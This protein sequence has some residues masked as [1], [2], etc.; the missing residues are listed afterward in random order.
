[1]RAHCRTTVVA[2]IALVLGLAHAGARHEREHERLESELTRAIDRLID[3]HFVVRDV[4]SVRVENL[5]FSENGARVQPTLDRNGHQKTTTHH[6]GEVYFRP[7]PLW[8]HIYP[9]SGDVET[10]TEAPGK[11]V[12]VA[13]ALRDLEELKEIGEYDL[14]NKI[15][16]LL[17]ETYQAIFE[18]DSLICIAMVDLHVELLQEVSDDMRGWGHLEFSLMSPVFGT[19]MT[20]RQRGNLTLEFVR[21][22]FREEFARQF[23][24]TPRWL[25]KQPPDMD[26]PR[27]VHPCQA[28]D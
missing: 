17:D 8:D 22:R 11:H 15:F 3:R 2:V 12:T 23:H 20:A 5:R 7:V 26:P 6:K 27:K 25:L 4:H 21:Y 24:D 18:S 1:M 19:S 9:R 14:E 10:T 16:R 13:L 28:D